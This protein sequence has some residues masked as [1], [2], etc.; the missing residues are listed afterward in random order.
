[1]STNNIIQ[2][3]C[4]HMEACKASDLFLSAGRY[5]AFRIGGT[6]VEQN[7]YQKILPEQIQEFVHASCQPGTWQQL[8]TEKDL[9]CGI[10]IPNLGRFRLNLSFQRGNPSIAIRRIPSG[11]LDHRKLFIPD[12][13][14]SMADEARGLILITGATGSGKSTTL[15]AL[16][17]HINSTV[18]KHIVTIEDPIEYAHEDLKSVVSQREI[19]TDTNDFATALKHVVR[20]NPD[21]IFIGEMRDMDTIQTAISAAMTGHL[22][23]ATMHTIDVTQTVE[24]IVTYF[25]EALREQ[26]SHDLAHTLIGI[27]SQRLLQRKDEPQERIPAFEFLKLTP[28]ARRLIASRELI[29]LPEVIKAGAQEGMTTFNRSVLKRFQDGYEIGRAHV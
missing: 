11:A 6:V 2:Q 23:C 19:G 18:S 24:R 17:H 21:A 4:A 20:Q 13:I 3:L 7:T 22:V 16:L 1:M 14:I 12:E 5:P 28:L 15:N 25:P 9:D 10:T 27:V 8:L 26:I 29:E